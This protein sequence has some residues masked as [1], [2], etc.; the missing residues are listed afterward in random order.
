[1]SASVR[2]VVVHGHFYQPPREDPW[3]ERIPRE[4]S[5]APFHDWNRRIEDECYRKVV[6]ALPFMSFDFGPTL[7]SWLEREAPETY[8]GIVEADR[9]SCRRLDGHGGAMAMPFHHAILPLSAPRDR[10]TEIR[11]GLADFRRRFGREPEGMW[12][13]ETAVDDA[14]LDAVAREGIGF[15]VLAPRQVKQPPARGLPGLYRTRGG[16]EI[17][18]FVYDGELSHGV[19]FGDLLEDGR[20][21][22][23]AVAGRDDR[24]LTS[25]ATDGETYGHHHRDGHRALASALEALEARDDVRLESYASFLARNPPA[26]EITIVEPS[27]WSCVHGVER[28]RSACGCGLEPEPAGGR[29]WRR[30]LRDAMTWLAGELHRIYEDQAGGFFADPWAVRDAY[31]E[32]VEASKDE[33]A[34]FVEERATRT[35]SPEERGR[36]LELLEMERN[37]LRLFTSCA[38]FFDD[39]ARLEA[40]QILRYAARAIELAEDAGPGLEE[41][42]RTRLAGAASNDPEVGDGRTLYDTRVRPATRRSVTR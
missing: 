17:A 8:R 34:R 3:L 30:P 11:W 18:V 2:S 19:A 31:G 7:L 29:E 27:S 5:A 13:P 39:L 23:G 16:R 40:V 36:A 15:T 1:M 28:W 14:T 12:L 41:E 10:L 21:L 35:L 4:P 24:A 9:L 37:A 38:W 22:A 33:K 32:V 42:L 20:R 25:V 6:D 26:E